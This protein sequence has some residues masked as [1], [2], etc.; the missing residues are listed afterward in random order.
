[1]ARYAFE[2][3]MASSSSGGWKSLFYF[4]VAAAGLGFA[5]YVYLVPYSKMERAV[6][7]GASAVVEQQR[8]A[9]AAVAE[10]DK[11]KADL[12][13]LT[14]AAA[15]KAAAEAKHKATITALSAQLKPGLEALGATV[16]GEDS[17]LS[18]SFPAAKMIDANGIDV[19][20]GGMA[21]VKILA[22]AAKKESARVRIRA[23]S[24]SAPPP[25]ELRSLFRTAGEMNA[26]R[27]ARVM[28]SLQSAGVQ[29]SRVTIVGDA[30][31][32]APRAARG[33]K[34]AAPPTADRVELE[35]EPRE[36]L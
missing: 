28:S 31:K 29:P 5:G 20:D 6:G 10:R 23:K 32:S 19:S 21:A 17:V 33:K 13:K 25:K 15:D 36:K 34:G 16:A 8:A 18:V 35:Q 3:P 14:S 7:S 30:D 11:L 4:A 22:E 24:S 27:A 26:V 9:A 1:M 2:D 12:A